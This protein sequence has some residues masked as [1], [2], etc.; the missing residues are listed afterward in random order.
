[1]RKQIRMPPQHAYLLL[2]RTRKGCK[3]TATVLISDYRGTIS[4]K[5]ARERLLPIGSKSEYRRSPPG[6]SNCWIDS[7][8]DKLF[9]ILKSLIILS[10]STDPDTF[11]WDSYR[12]GLYIYGHI[13]HFNWL[14]L[15]Q[16]ATY[17]F[18]L[19]WHMLTRNIHQ[20]A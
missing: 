14:F 19:N 4:I 20:S 7:I 12:N 3:Q 1:M 13:L 8:G 15:E 9:A 6:L 17:L 18:Y 16:L 5:S 10:I 2:W 11:T